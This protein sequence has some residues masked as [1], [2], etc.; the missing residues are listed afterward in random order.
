MIAGVLLLLL[1]LYLVFARERYIDPDQKV[2]PPCSCPAIGVCPS[3]CQAWE[4][5]VEAIAPSGASA[6]DYIS[7]ASAF[8]TTV[9]TPAASR[10]TEAQVDTF[11]ASSAGTVSGVDRS[12]MKQLIMTGF[13]ITASGTAAQREAK[14]S[15]FTP[16]QSNL[17][18]DMGRD[19]LRTR[20]EDKYTPAVP[21]TNTQF[22]EGAYAPVTQTTPLAPGDWDDPNVRWKGPRP[23][24][25]CP[26]AENIM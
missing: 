12:S 10:P 5:K 25:V 26:C 16:S 9:Y 3:A 4:S 19:E 18:P 21:V 6:A 22:S 14:S 23:A 20:A 17:A 8:Y 2:Q 15:D 1:I 7:V 13:H 24:S 11:L